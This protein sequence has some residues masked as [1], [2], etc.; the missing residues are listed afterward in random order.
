MEASQALPVFLSYPFKTNIPS[1]LFVTIIWM[2]EEKIEYGNHLNSI[3]EYLT[4][5][6][7]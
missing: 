2:E 4:I 1:A 5:T 3:R 7:E 6:T